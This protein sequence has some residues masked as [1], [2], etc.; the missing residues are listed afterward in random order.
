[1]SVA[2]RGLDARLRPYA[3]QLVAWAMK[4]GVPVT[5]T[6]V[7]RSMSQQQALRSNYELC[8][9]KGLQGQRVSLTPGMS[10]A[11]PANRPGDSGHNY[12]LAWDSVVPAEYQ[13][14]WNEV[15]RAAGWHV[16]ANDEIHAEY[17]DWRQLVS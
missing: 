1:M 14:W 8:Q 9:R 11:W 17:P 12:G 4:N 2:L 10:C 16:P 6:S 5:V 13:S 15:R 7:Y 3:E